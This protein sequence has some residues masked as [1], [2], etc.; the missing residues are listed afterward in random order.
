MRWVYFA[1]IR[2][3]LLWLYMIL[4]IS[5]IPYHRSQHGSYV[6]TAICSSYAPMPYVSP[7]PDMLLYLADPRQHLGS[8]VISYMIS[9]C[10]S[11]LPNLCLGYTLLKS[12][13][14]AYDFRKKAMASSTFL[15]SI[16]LVW[17]RILFRT[18]AHPI[19]IQRAF[20]N[21]TF[22]Y[23]LQLSAAAVDTFGSYRFYWCQLCH[24][25][26]SLLYISCV[27]C[28]SIPVS[29]MTGSLNNVV[30]R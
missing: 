23:F 24:A 26:A 10:Y 28:I 15:I 17:V 4:F 3:G 22:S 21:R 7:A 2:R 19:R 20:G 5:H 27:T 6:S 14:S 11:G 30:S 1:L 18:F 13:L 8:L 12:V 25:S 29:Y 9:D 16:L